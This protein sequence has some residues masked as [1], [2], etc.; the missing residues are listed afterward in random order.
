M[1][2]NY[3]YIID[4][5]ITA[6]VA[7]GSV[8]NGVGGWHTLTDEERAEHGWHPCDVF[9]EGY[10]AKTQIRSVLPVL[11]FDGERI[12]VEYTLIDKP[13][14]QVR[15]ESLSSLA[16]IRYVEEIAN[17]TCEETGVI[18][19]ASRAERLNVADKIDFLER[20]PDIESTPWKDS[21]GTW[22]SV[23]AEDLRTLL[24]K[25]RAHVDNAYRAEHSVA[26]MIMAAE[27]IEDI[28]SIDLQTAFKEALSGA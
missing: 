16:E 13:F 26:T 28:I 9:N 2:V 21:S 19:S 27:S 10:D 25:M 5:A 18:Q 11:S 20:S 4:G 14:E 22:H 12:K 23:S 17:I 15:D 8:F 7:M 6:P 24:E 1:N 3:G